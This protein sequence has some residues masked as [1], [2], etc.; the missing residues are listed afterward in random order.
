MIFFIALWHVGADA[1]DSPVG[2]ISTMTGKVFI[3]R[4]GQ[5]LVGE[6]GVRIF[7]LDTIQTE[8][9]AAVGIILRDNT[10][11]SL[12]ESSSLTIAQYRFEPVEQDHVL[13]IKLSKGKFL[14]N[15]GIIGKQ[16][17]KSVRC[18]MPIGTLG[19]L[20]TRFLVNIEE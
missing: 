8:K 12:G 1:A 18:L 5:S 13:D 2:T 9:K 14:Y 19:T 16:K 11:L 6:K 3:L 4:E 10:M 17:P 15:S 20:G 7:E